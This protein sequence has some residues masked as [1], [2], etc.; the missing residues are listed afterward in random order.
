V[1]INAA[2]NAIRATLSNNGMLGTGIPKN[3][4]ISGRVPM[5]RLR[6]LSAVNR[7][8]LVKNLAAAA[9]AVSILRGVKSRA[10]DL[11]HLN[12]KDAE[13]VALGY[14]ENATQ[15]DA[16]KYRTYVQGSRCDNCLLLQ[17]SSGASYRPC[18]LFAGKVV[19][20]AGWCSGWTAEI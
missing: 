15:V 6:S 7:R 19:S 18:N 5:S 9:A 20:A 8:S 2:K 17:G 13:A 14:V 11:P 10:T 12:V 16:K 4:S 3:I 1:K